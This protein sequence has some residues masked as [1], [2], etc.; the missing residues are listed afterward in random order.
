MTDQVGTK[1]HELRR[2]RASVLTGPRQ[3][4]VH[5]VRV[6]DVGSRDVLVRV[7]A[8]GV[9]G[10]DT[11]FYQ[12]GRIGDLVVEGPII[13]G[14]ETAGVIVDVGVEVDRARIGERVSIE[15]QRPCRRCDHC[16][17]G[18]YNQCS[19]IEFYGA[20]PIHGSF[21]EF[22]V[23]PEDFAYRLPD[24]M[25]LEE[26]ALLEPLSV[27]IYACRTGG[28]TAG[29]RVLIAGA[30][31][32]GL[33][34]AQVAFAFGAA[35]VSVTDP[36]RSRRDFAEEYAEVRGMVPAALEGAPPFADVFIDASGA[37]SAIVSGVLA[38]H[39]RGRVVLVGMGM[40]DVTLP[41]SVIQHRE[42]MVTGTFRYAHTW[43]L[44]IELA[45][46]GKVRLAPLVTSRHPLDDVE[47]ALLA[48]STDPSS[49]KSVVV[50]TAMKE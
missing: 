28:I 47:S 2:M 34:I 12:A 46:T 40:D 29:S 5:E 23:I 15:P 1:E 11:H 4:E 24:A 43:P 42:L 18:D 41:V 9:C 14:H 39:P 19:D 21:A 33:L 44:A 36:Q 10:S 49:I 17:N 27:A 13:L 25:T 20:Y 48:A 8:V 16:R 37:P 6:P 32:I 22:A 31:P 35:E 45:S 7:E 50:P 3:L 38:V 26:G 30:G